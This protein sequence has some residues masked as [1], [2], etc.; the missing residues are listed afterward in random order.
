MPSGV[1]GLVGL[2]AVLFGA[3]CG[4]SAPPY[5]WAPTKH[6]LAQALPLGTPSARVAA[7]FDSLGFT[8][9]RSAWGDSVLYA[10]K[11]EPST[12]NIVF[13]TL[14][15]VAR[16]DVHSRLSDISTHVVYTGP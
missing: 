13:G 5:D 8:R 11:R 15:V 16:F 2:A 14:Q 12:R 1:N 6:S 4:L 10:S 7:V 9:G 3:S